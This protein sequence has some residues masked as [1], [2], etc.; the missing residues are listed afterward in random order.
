MSAELAPWEGKAKW[1]VGPSPAGAPSAD[2][3][4][5]KDW[6]AAPDKRDCE[7]RSKSSDLYDGNKTCKNDSTEQC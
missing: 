7:V 3:D 1:S 4:W 5:E 6:R 2:V